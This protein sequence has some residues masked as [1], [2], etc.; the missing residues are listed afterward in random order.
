M[1]TFGWVIQPPFQMRKKIEICGS[2]SPKV[3]GVHLK[4]IFCNVSFVRNVLVKKKNLLSQIF[5]FI[6]F[7]TFPNWNAEGCFSQRKKTHLQT[8]ESLQK[9]GVTKYHAPSQPLKASLIYYGTPLCSVYISQKL[10]RLTPLQ[11]YWKINFVF[12]PSGWTQRR[13]WKTQFNGEKL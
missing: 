9:T 6:L 13:F 4:C 11:V 5:F 2:D 12:F 1:W 8:Q 7:C 10:L 3:L